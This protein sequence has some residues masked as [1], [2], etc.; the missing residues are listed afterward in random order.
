[1]KLR[2]KKIEFEIMH[3]SQLSNASKHT[4]TQ[5]NRI[6][7]QHPSFIP[8]NTDIEYTYLR[9]ISI[10]VGKP[11]YLIKHTLFVFNSG[12]FF[13]FF[14]SSFEIDY[15][16]ERWNHLYSWCS[17]MIMDA[18]FKSYLYSLLLLFRTMYELTNQ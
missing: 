2:N 12:I 10:N 8:G 1:M 3:Q 6:N 18:L 4:N 7:R 11:T 16:I 15:G 9:F 13:F 17:S 14:F 5:N